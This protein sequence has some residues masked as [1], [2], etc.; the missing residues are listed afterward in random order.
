MSIGCR[1]GWSEGLE[2][3]KEAYSYAV[4]EATGPSVIEKKQR[5]EERHL[6]QSYRR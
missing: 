5:A 4:D 3:K 2:M 6:P 1:V